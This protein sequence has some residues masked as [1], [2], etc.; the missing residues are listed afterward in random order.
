MLKLS[1]L[2]SFQNCS[3]MISP[4]MSVFG[5]GGEDTP[6]HVILFHALLGHCCSFP[7]TILCTVSKQCALN[8]FFLT[9]CLQWHFVWFGFFLFTH[10]NSGTKNGSLRG[11]KIYPLLPVLSPC[12]IFSPDFEVQDFRIAEIRICYSF[13][14][15]IAHIAK[16][17]QPI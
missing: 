15:Y 14:N 11:L 5:D 6:P 4:F 13:L 3:D 7:C 10:F 8:V 1:K 12:Q 2:P 16:A 17:M 9:S